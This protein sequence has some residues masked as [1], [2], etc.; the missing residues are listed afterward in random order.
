MKH[1]I[2]FLIVFSGVIRAA[3]YEPFPGFEALY[4]RA[5][6]VGI[7]KIGERDVPDDESGQRADWIGPHRF[8]QI[9]SVMVFKGSK[10][11]GDVARLADRRIELIGDGKMVMA[12]S[13]EILTQ[14]K[15][16]LVFLMGRY[17]KN[18]YQW[19]EVH[20]EGS[21]LPVSPQTNVR[22]IDVKNPI[23]SCHRIV[24]D[25]TAYCQQ[26]LKHALAQQKIVDQFGQQGGADQ[27]ATAPES[28]SEGGDKPQP[29]S[30]GR[31][32]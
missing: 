1:V 29:E 18:R 17:E 31:S 20:A 23:Q 21:V 19:D 27:P 4:K 6:F 24:A 25:Y 26:L 7:V 14:E 15:T 5:S 13:E 9:D 30:E 11:S 16:F 32:R 3:F 22:L 12:P 28:K 10:I 8:F 2:L